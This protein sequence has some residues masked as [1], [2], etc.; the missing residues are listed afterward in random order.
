METNLESPAILL[1]GAEVSASRRAFLQLAGFGIA[2]SALPSCVRIPAGNAV[3]W[4][5][6]PEDV[7]AGRA[8]WVATTCAACPS[9]CGV[10]ARCRDGRP[11]K[12]EG[13]KLNPIGAGGLCASGQA[14]ILEL[15]DSQRLAGP[16]ALRQPTTWREL[17]AG[18]TRALDAARG[19][20]KVRLLTG[21]IH[22]PSTLAQ[23]ERFNASFG[24]AAHVMY[25]ALSVSAV[26]DAHERTHG[27]RVLPDYRFDRARAIVS[28]DA[29]FLATWIAP[30][31][32]ARQYVERPRTPARAPSHVQF[33]A[34]LS[35]T[36]SRADERV[37][38]APHEL[39]ATLERLCSRLAHAAGES[40][41]AQG[42]DPR[43]D[44][45]ARD[46]W[47]A[48][49]ESLVVCGVNDVDC[50]ALVNEANERLGNY[51]ATL[52]IARPSQQRRG[53][54]RAL[55]RL[56]EE[57]ERGEIDVLLVFGCNP[58][59]DLPTRSAGAFAKAKTLIVGAAMRDE[60]ATNAHWIAATP[61]YLEAWDD[62]E[63]VAGKFGLTQPTIPALRDARTLRASLARW[64]GDTR[65]DYELIREHWRTAI[66]PLFAP[67]AFA[68]LF[69]RAQHDGAIEAPRE[70]TAPHFANFRGRGELG[71]PLRAA[72]GPVLVLYAKV[73]AMDGAHAHNPW[74]QELPD[75]ISKATWGNYVCV[76][77][78]FAARAGLVDGDEVRISAA[79]LSD[80]L[81]APICVQRGQHDDV[82]ALA[83]GYGRAGTERFADIGPQWLE[84]KPTVEKDRRVGVNAARL[85]SWSAQ[86]LRSDVREVKLTPTGRRVELARTQDYDSLE[87]PAGLAPHG[88]EERGHLPTAAA[89]AQSAHGA[90]SH[91]GAAH[92]PKGLWVD[93]HAAKG[94]RWG[95]VIDLERCTGCSAC[96]I[97]CQ[98]E[99]NIP[100]VGRDEVARHREMHWLRID[101]YF[102]GAGAAAR[103]QFQP[104]LCQHCANAPCE[105]VCP[106]LATVH[107]SEGLNQQVYNRC[108]GTRY[109]ANT[110][111]YKVRRFNWFDYP[112]ED[113]LQNHSLNPDVTVRSR[114]V[115]EKCSLCVQRIQEAKHEARRLGEPLADGAVSTAC[116]QSCPTQAI[117]F[118]DLADPTS[119]VAK[120]A[121]DPR[122]Y[123]LLEELNVGPSIRYLA[124]HG[125][126]G[127]AKEQ[128]G[129]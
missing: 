128:H 6:A 129:R 30:V 62:A 25:D 89:L 33:E 37:L 4:T 76:S 65:D 57:L 95:M 119:T 50:Q 43:I 53:D 99:N 114:G 74:L 22:S 44:A 83:L 36:G 59:Y 34:R 18:V 3:T 108:V 15:Y 29:D 85:L 49:G 56:V 71:A 75:P 109:C 105:A 67:A 24:D 80:S 77:P 103:A 121:A 101:R 7:V 10:L 13:N 69:R 16:Q 90:S 5:H 117:V 1:P 81:E 20:G 42:S 82:I 61:H 2:A 35:L 52:D 112:R 123:V 79:D 116:Q 102:S 9:A 126:S 87:L 64:M 27:L 124:A 32:Y 21:T 28:F 14:S 118:G 66:A 26:L 17:D 122:A 31:Q 11:V 107:S 84:A 45:L 47:N 94:P 88:H 91:G 111:P 115:M 70:A 19:G 54:D 125:P 55:A 38:L 39:R 86:H 110:C 93:D 51:G 23:I 68:E 92:A 96:V 104:M 97:G 63:P 106:V 8:W 58:A 127:R 12:L 78:A 120:A 60:T 113:R 46:L 73:G 100:V 40:G 98:S 41:D 48:R 72:G